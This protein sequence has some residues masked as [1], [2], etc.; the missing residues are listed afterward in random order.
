MVSQ[1][2]NVISL[3]ADMGNGEVQTPTIDLPKVNGQDA[4]V[5]TSNRIVHWD[6]EWHWDATYTQYPHQA[7]GGHI[8][9]LGLT[10]ANQIWNESTDSIVSWARQQGGIAGF[11]HFQFLDDN[12]PTSLS[13]C[14]PIEYPVEVALGACDFISEDVG[15]S[16]SFIHAYYRLLNCGFR[17]GFAAGS[18]YPCGSAIGQVL[19]YAQVAGGQLTYSNWI[20]A[21]ATGRTM[22][23]RN[24]HNEFVSLVVNG[25]ATPGDEIQLSA[26]GSVPVTVT[27]TAQTSLTGTLE[28]VHN[29]VVVASQQAAA[30]PGS[31]VT[32]STTVD[33]P[34]SGWLC[35]RRMAP[36][37]GHQAHTAAVF[38]TVNHAPVRAS[39]VDAEFYVQ[40][41]TN[42]LYNT[43]PG[44]VWNGYFS[45]TLA[46][47]QARY[48]AALGVYQQ[49]AADALA[50]LAVGT[51]S[52]PD[53]ALRLAYSATMAVHGGQAPYTWAIASG[54]LPPG[55]ALNAASGAITGM[56]T[57]TGTFCFGVEV[58]DASNP[59]QAAI[60]VFYLTITSLPAVTIWPSSAVPTVVDQGADD[61]VELG[62][63]F[64]S[65][66]AGRITGIRF[67]KSSENTGTH[68]G[69]FWTSTGTLLASATFTNE[70]ISGWQEA[71]F[72][73]P[74]AIAANTVY[75]AS[76]H[77][78]VGHYSGDEYYFATKGVDNPPLHALADGLS[79]PNG[80]YAYN[81]SSVFPNQTWASA[82][83]WV[84]VDFQTATGPSL[85]SIAVT[86]ANPTILTGVSQQFTA[87]GTYSDGSMQDITSQVTW[88]S[89]NTVV[90][91][92]NTAGLATAIAA[93]TSIISATEGTNIGSTLLTVQAGPL[94]ITTT[95]LPNPAKNL[96]YSA[97]L[98]ASG[99]TAPETWS[100]AS[101]GLPPGLTLTAS[102]G[103]ITG[104]PA[105]TGIFTF[106]VVAGD[107]SA[108]VETA[109]KPFTI[110]V[111]SAATIWAS[112]NAP[113]RVD[114]GPDSAVELGVKFKSDVAG[115]I[116]GIR[117]YKAAA[118]T[119]THVGNLWTSSGTQLATATFS[120]ETVSGW[121]QVLFSN[122]VLI[123]TNTI[124]V[125][126]YHCTVGH[127]SEDDSYFAA[128]GVD[129]PPLHALAN[130]V[131]G[132]NGVYSYGASS[133]FPNQTW[134]AANYWVDVVFQAGPAASLPAVTAS[135]I[136][137]NVEC[138][139]NVVLTA[140]ATGAGTLI[141]QWFDN[142]TNLLS[143]ETGQTLKLKQVHSDNSGNY[144]VVVTNLDGA[145]TNVALVSVV[146]TIP[147]EI[148]RTASPQ[149][150][151]AGYNGLT[152]LS[153]LTALIG[154]SDACSGSVNITQQ[155]AA[156]TEIPVGTNTVVFY[157]DDGNGN[158]NTCTGTVTVNAAPL[159][160]PTILSEQVLGD[161]SFKLT[162]SG[163]DTQPYKVRASADLNLPLG[164]WDVLTNS[165]FG[166]APATF[167][168][169]S[170]ASQPVRF[171]RV[172]SP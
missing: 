63:K 76:Y 16:D 72:A 23:S 4:S 142:Q 123:A 164:S 82:N 90:A 25:T 26:A 41:M 27:W 46:M 85:N 119:G 58:S 75:V 52:L 66:V 60:Q 30:G 9:A 96:A 130:G 139:S 68:I 134:S 102:S 135:P 168:D 106:T 103:V 108:R 84:D 65:D 133:V 43:S 74:V 125:A 165:A 78:E 97:S 137:S 99:G 160:A 48:Q 138:G 1:D 155:P 34:N 162:F 18:D 70:T 45:T 169:T 64:Q 113:V 42:L 98:T 62:V 33:F 131:S 57:N 156:G 11:A 151:T 104:T 3:L 6:A 17:P 86:P 5:S 49:I 55:L 51:T 39:V 93:G 92:V 171:Y 109:M 77:C 132:P 157:V 29:G 111:G 69:N 149:T 10:N 152:I 54:S 116:T 110:A 59:A 163:P 136:T 35:A 38:V 36:S 117:F 145:A 154:A 47:A 22:V 14:T 53:G 24:G 31:P 94:S 44:G 12:F 114:S 56:P 19:T 15:G 8:V 50:A 71:I 13:C 172:G 28:L 115:S 81:A 88:N 32:L 67:Y 83:Y 105:A 147:P 166:T 140:N 153:N 112:T 20:H 143:G 144:T 91:K 146:D 129:N 21:I 120:G 127:Y 40:W 148:V 124:Y 167:I 128:S 61:P 118:N 100:I 79:G 141:Y 121:Q 122:P 158:T 101:G 107:S 126:S 37:T 2:F 150:V 89:T 161:G 80:L 87:T 159:V 170:A 95:S 7:L 73:T